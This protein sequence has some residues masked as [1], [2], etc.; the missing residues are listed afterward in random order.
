MKLLLV[1]HGALA[2]GLLGSFEMIAGKN[3]SI[4]AISLTDEGIGSFST[5]LKQYLEERKNEEVLILCD[6]KGGTPFNEAYRAFLAD[7]KQIR[8]ISGMNLPMLIEIG[9]ML[10]ADS[11]LEQLVEIGINAGITSIEGVVEETRN[12]DEMIEF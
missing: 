10:Q 8:V 12:D 5:Q 4:S 11:E 1:S 3:D 6:I 9:V 2:T 7:P